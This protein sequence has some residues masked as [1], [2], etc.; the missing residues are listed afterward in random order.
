MQGW[1]V[2][3]RLR[4]TDSPLPE[5]EAWLK[6]SWRSSPEWGSGGRGKSV[7]ARGGR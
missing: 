4:Q 3:A 2:N 1:P 6:S 5:S 7:A